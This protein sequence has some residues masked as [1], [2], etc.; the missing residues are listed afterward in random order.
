MGHKMETEENKP[1]WKRQLLL[2]HQINSMAVDSLDP[3]FSVFN[4]FV[5]PLLFL[6]RILFFTIIT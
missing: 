3:T 1:T 4:F 6:Q 2:D 5:W